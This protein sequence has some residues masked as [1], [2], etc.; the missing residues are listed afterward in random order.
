MKLIIFGA[1][2][3]GKKLLTYALRKDVEIVGV[4][5]NDNKKWGA[6]ISG[7]TIKSLV[8]LTKIYYDKVL[9]VAPGT[10]S[11]SILLHTIAGVCHSLP[12]F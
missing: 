8:E 9:V 10:A 4:F 3:N 2:R 1:G 5:D 12:S 7:Y 6:N 11:I